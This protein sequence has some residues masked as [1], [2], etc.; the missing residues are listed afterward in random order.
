MNNRT[1]L[2]TLVKPAN[3]KSSQYFQK[4]NTYIW[5]HLKYFWLS[6]LLEVKMIKIPYFRPINPP[7]QIKMTGP[8]VNTVLFV[9]FMIY[10]L[11]FLRTY[12]CWCSWDPNKRLILQPSA[13]CWLEKEGVPLFWIKHKMIISNNQI[14]SCFYQIFHFPL[15]IFQSCNI[16][17]TVL[18][19]DPLFPYLNF[20]KLDN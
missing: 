6:S 4:I 10:C 19:T 18:N 5:F 16:Q 11:L 13:Q 15:R 7:K 12:Q 20:D 8:S 9:N 3:G 14:Q 2:F 1:Q 17:K